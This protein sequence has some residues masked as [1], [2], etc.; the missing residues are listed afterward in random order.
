M[1][2]I[3]KYL[4]QIV[5][6]S[7]LVL[8]VALPVSQAAPRVKDKVQKREAAPQGYVSQEN[9]PR[10][11]IKEGLYAGIE[12]GKVSLLEGVRSIKR[13]YRLEEDYKIIFNGLEVDW[14]ALGLIRIPPYSS[15]KLIMFEGQVRE[16]VLVEVPS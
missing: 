15:V 12:K 5:C 1:N 3:F 11:I 13:S 14:K 4:A 9:D 2:H 8:T 7:I 6:F 10:A 16:I